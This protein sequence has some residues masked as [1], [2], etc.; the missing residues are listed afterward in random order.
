MN[1]FG[2]IGLGRMGGGLAHQALEKGI[3]V[4]GASRSGAPKNLVAAGLVEIRD[5]KAF[6]DKLAAPRARSATRAPSRA[7]S[8]AVARPMP[9]EAPV[10]TTRMVATRAN[11]VPELKRRT[12]LKRK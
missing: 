11:A 7:N 6:R 5:F 2:V 9:A 8:T 3:K 12:P 10:M 1:Q 4:V